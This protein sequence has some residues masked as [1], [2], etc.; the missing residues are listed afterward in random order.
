[1]KK[2]E[3]QNGMISTNNITTLIRSR[4]FLI[5]L[6]ILLTLSMSIAYVASVPRE[7]ERFLSLSTL[8]SNM[9]VGDYY[10]NN[11]KDIELLDDIRWYIQVYNNMGSAEYIAVRVKLLN[12]EQAAP[13][14]NTHTPSPIEHI[15]EFK[16][17]VAKGETVTIPFEWSITSILSIDSSKVIKGISINGDMV[18]VDVRADDGKDFRI[19]FELWRYNT[20]SKEF[21][22]SWVDSSNEKR[23]VWNQIWFNVKS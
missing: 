14:D 23:S 18:E 8:G 16:H 3:D 7:H 10:P 17:L 2:N 20:E 21:E 22:F 19:V 1:L 5:N 11:K 13:D 6:V 9:M 15:Y 4:I 12:S